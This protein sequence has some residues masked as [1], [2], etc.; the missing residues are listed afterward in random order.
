MIIHPCRQL[1]GLPLPQ[2]LPGG[3]DGIQLGCL[4]PGFKGWLGAGATVS[5]TS[6][7]MDSR[8]AQGGHSAP[9][10]KAALAQLDS[11]LL[12]DQKKWD[13][14]QTLHLAVNTRQSEM[15]F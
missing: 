15:C 1:S 2:G 6:S 10:Q 3:L 7:A 13:I 14:A 8:M 12:C 11:E 5:L 9:W 4:H